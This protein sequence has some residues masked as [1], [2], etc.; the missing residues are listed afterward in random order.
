MG[1][2]EDEIM[3]VKE[4]RENAP[5]NEQIKREPALIE[6]GTRLVLAM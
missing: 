5:L 3:W 2:G 4:C 1:R 6:D